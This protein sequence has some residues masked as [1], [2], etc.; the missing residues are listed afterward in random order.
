MKIYATRKLFQVW[1]VLAERRGSGMASK[2]SRSPWINESMDKY[3][4]GSIELDLV[5]IGLLWQKPTYGKLNETESSI[6]RESANSTRHDS[7]HA[8]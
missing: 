2:R 5:M 3:L 6:T 1:S 8:R 4:R 7:I